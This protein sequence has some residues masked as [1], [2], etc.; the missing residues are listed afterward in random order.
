MV[1]ESHFWAHVESDTPPPA[2]GSE[3]SARALRHLY[4]DNDT[5]LDFTGNA[6]LGNTFDA[7]AALDQE[8]A[9]KERDAERLK[10]TIQQAMGDAS[11]ATFANGVA[12]FKRAKDGTRID[13]KALATAHPDIAARYTGT[14]PGSRR[15]LLSRQPDITERTATC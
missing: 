7:L 5:T 11:K 3:S 10:Q 9:A 15:F 12:T 6:E 4:R 8:I 1:L 13:T 2:D 14:T